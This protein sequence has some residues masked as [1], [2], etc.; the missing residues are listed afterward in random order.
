MENMLGSI[1]T[2][3][4]VGLLMV[5][6]ISETMQILIFY[7][8]FADIIFKIKINRQNETPKH[9]ISLILMTLDS[10]LYYSTNIS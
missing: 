2:L 4:L 5:L 8:I 9:P 1:S 10:S 7:R 3:N 6:V